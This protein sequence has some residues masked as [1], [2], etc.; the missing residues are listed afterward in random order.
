M[1]GKEY[2]SFS[3]RER[4]GIICL[5]ALVIIIAV[6][7]RYLFRTDQT[8]VTEAASVMPQTQIRIAA[9]KM[10]TRIAVDSSLSGFQP[11]DKR[12]TT[13]YLSAAYYRRQGSPRYNGYKP[14]KVI[15]INGA[16]TTAFI[17]LPGIGSK[18]A[19]RIVLFRDR[20]GGF[21]SVE[22]VREVY[23]LQDSVFSLIRKRLKCDSSLVRKID[24]NKCTVEELKAHPYIRW[25][26]ATALIAYRE[27]HGDFK[28]PND[29]GN[30]VNINETFIQKISP[31]F[32]FNVTKQ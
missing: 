18:L 32:L 9:A 16:D 13:Q 23:G 2:L 7:P 25:N 14:A 8:L 19:S 17:A 22:Q 31:Y 30:L 27:Q 3:K 4:T 24:I 28:S 20:L 21:V 26:N 1:T 12:T 29:L 11:N 6:L 10:E 15:E 5:V